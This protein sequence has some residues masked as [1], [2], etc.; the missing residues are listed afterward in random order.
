MAICC[1]TCH[2]EGVGTVHEA[3]GGYAGLL[4][5]RGP[6]RRARRTHRLHDAIGDE[7]SVEQMHYG[8]GE[9]DEMDRWANECF[10][11]ALVDVGLD[12][13]PQVRETP[14][15]YFAWAATTT[16]ARYHDSADGVPDG[17]RIPYWSWDGLVGAAVADEERS[18]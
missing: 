4:A 18:R 6:D 8:N 14:Y 16:M 10:D 13:D 3:A 17:L 12:W 7:T 5:R 1:A 11:H 15:D 9:H 2:P